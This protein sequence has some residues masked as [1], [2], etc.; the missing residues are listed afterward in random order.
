MLSRIITG[1]NKEV[2][3]PKHSQYIQIE[4][5]RHIFESLHLDTY[6]QHNHETDKISFEE[7]LSADDTRLLNIL[8]HEKAHGILFKTTGKTRHRFDWYILY[9]SLMESAKTLYSDCGACSSP[10]SPSFIMVDYVLSVMG[11]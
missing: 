10:E 5:S 3:N 2:F 9:Q 1:I 8:L 6:A 7:T 11:N 4:I